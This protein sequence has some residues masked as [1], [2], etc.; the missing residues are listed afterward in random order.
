M[1]EQE[2]AELLRPAIS[3]LGLELLGVEL[4]LSRGSGLV[5]V[6][7]DVEGR[8]IGLEDCEAASREL[9]ALLDLHDPIASRY[10]LEV[11][12]PGV[13]RPLFTPAQFARFT[14]EQVRIDLRVPVGG[15][16]RLQGRVVA[17]EGEQIVLGIDGGEQRVAHGNVQRARLKPDMDALFGGTPKGGTKGGTKQ[18]AGKAGAR[19]PSG[20]AGSGTRDVPRSKR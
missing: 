14:G 8:A 3:A 2:L 20:K 1:H 18:G 19:G 11:S 12:S 15:R 9:S 17:V 6:Y 4:A 7:L 10:T 13:E 5:R 16:R